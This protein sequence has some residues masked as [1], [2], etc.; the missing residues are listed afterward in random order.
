VPGTIRV[1]EQIDSRYLLEDFFAKLAEF[2][3]NSPP[4]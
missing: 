1:C 4:P 2:S 3:E